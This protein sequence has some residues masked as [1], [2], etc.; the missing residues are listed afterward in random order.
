MKMDRLDEQQLV[1]QF[2][3]RIKEIERDISQSNDILDLVRQS[4]HAALKYV[5]Y[6]GHNLDH[7]VKLLHKT[8]K[9][10]DDWE[11]NGLS[12]ETDIPA[13]YMALDYFFEAGVN[14]LGNPI[15][16]L[17][18]RFG[19]PGID[20]ICKK[21]IALFGKYHVLDKQDTTNSFEG[22]LIVDCQDCK[23]ENY[24][25]GPCLV[26]DLL[27]LIQSFPSNVD[28]LI[29]HEVP[30]AAR[31]AMSWAL[32]L[33]PS[34]I[35]NSIHF[36]TNETILEFVSRENLPPFMA[37]GQFTVNQLSKYAPKCLPWKDLAEKKFKLDEK[38]RNMAQKMLENY[39]YQESKW[40]MY[41]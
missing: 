15:G 14:R 6:T 35:R 40:I 18:R 20:S 30:W 32:K 17:R 37:N 22:T 38:K 36:T 25:I 39:L 27:H 41:A 10:W 1:E 26:R 3:A 16:I 11:L 4:D 2:R 33:A 5:R 29:F 31:T 19:I 23:W 21:I 24:M 12:Y 28:H 13:E 8:A 7:A 34:S 9:L